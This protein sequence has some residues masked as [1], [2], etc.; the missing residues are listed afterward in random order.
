MPTARIAVVVLNYRTPDLTLQAAA[1]A[2][3]DVDAARDCVVVVDN[4]SPDD[5][6]DLI[7]D[8]LQELGQPHVRL[9]RSPVNGGF[10]AGNNVGI[11]AVSA[12]AYVLLN[13][14]TIVRPGAIP[15]L[16]STLTAERDRGICSPR[17]E[18]EDGEPQI[19]CFRQHSPFSELI[20]GARTG[21]VTKALKHFD[22]PL[23]VQKHK[24]E[25]QWTSFACVMIDK[26]VFDSIGLLDEGFFMY[27]EDADFCRETTRAGFKIVHDPSARVVHL[28]GK[29]SPVKEAT[30]LKQARPAYYYEARGRYFRRA[31]G[32]LGA[33]AANALWSMG[34]ALALPRELV[35]QKERH[36]VQQEFLDNWRGTF[37]KRGTSEKRGTFERHSPESQEPRG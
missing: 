36:T 5:S 12:E 37:E 14:D 19:S 21:L 28:R 16:Y 22:V 6:A 7:E 2:A 34:R 4:C 1:S 8:G 29:S 20:K 32:P 15:T 31:Y 10:A 3:A 11:R 30:R 24:T 17:L 18:Y 27:Y 25:V 9:V 26:R 13:S 23:G 35:G 33:L